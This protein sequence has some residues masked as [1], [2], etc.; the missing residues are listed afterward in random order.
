MRLLL[1][2]RL[3]FGFPSSSDSGGVS[4]VRLPPPGDRCLPSGS[5][6]GR[7][8]YCRSKSILIFKLFG[9]LS[10]QS[11]GSLDILIKREFGN[12]SRFTVHVIKHF[13]SS[14]EGLWFRLHK[15]LWNALKQS[16]AA[17]SGLGVG[18][19]GRQKKKKKQKTTNIFWEVIKVLDGKYLYFNPCD[20]LP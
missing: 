14:A 2:P 8:I 20:E 1:Y 11:N 10:L 6:R 12:I 4:N 18:V 17:C 3:H 7:G 19:G 15:R 13:L 5:G 16:P 9:S